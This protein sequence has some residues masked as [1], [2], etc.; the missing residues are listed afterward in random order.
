MCVPKVVDPELWQF[1]IGAEFLES[2]R[3]IALIRRSAH[4][5]REHQSIFSPPL[6]GKRLDF[7]NLTFM[8][9]EHRNHKG[10]EI[11]RS[12]AH[13][14]FFGGP[15]TKRGVLSPFLRRGAKGLG[16]PSADVNR[17]PDPSIANHKALQDGVR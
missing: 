1:V 13:L 8:F 14:G 5:G 15:K 4:F 17:D 2:A 12:P 7:A 16:S 6:A 11:D 10:R 3:N 9:Q